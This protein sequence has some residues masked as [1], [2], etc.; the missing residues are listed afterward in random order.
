ML[1]KALPKGD[2]YLGNAFWGN[3]VNS[4]RYV[5]GKIFNPEEGDEGNTFKQ[6]YDSAAK[7]VQAE[8]KARLEKASAMKRVD[9]PRTSL[10]GSTLDKQLQQIG[11]SRAGSLETIVKRHINMNRQ[12]STSVLS[13]KLPQGTDVTEFVDGVLAQLNG[14]PT[15]AQVDQAILDAY[16]KL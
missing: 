8:L 13:Q 10:E 4:S 15:V 11:S 14:S 16:E 3:T 5:L 1:Q 12:T 6:I 7:N 2:T 9:E